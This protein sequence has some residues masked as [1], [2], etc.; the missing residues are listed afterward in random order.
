MAWVWQENRLGQSHVDDVDDSAKVP[1]GT[2]MRAYDPD[3]GA[4][5]FIYLKGV[6][7]TAVGSWVTYN[8]DDFSTALLAGDAIGPVAVAMA[9]TVANKY[10]WYMIQGKTDAKMAAS[11]AD[12]AA[13]YIDGTAGLADDDTVAG[14]R[15]WNA[16]SAELADSVAGALAEVEIH[17]PFVNNIAD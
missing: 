4:G 8:A 9:A 1:V 2:I 11:T 15:I 3:L 14:D 7:S 16:K 6:A 5:E 12:N 10:G 13:L 17:R